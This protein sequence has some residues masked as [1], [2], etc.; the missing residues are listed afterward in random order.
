MNDETSNLVL[1]HRRAMREWQTGAD[2]YF[3]DIIVRLSAIEHHI[4]GLS[5]T[6]AQHGGEIDRI[7]ARL[8]RIEKRL[9]LSEG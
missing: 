3:K 1:E 2:Q 4:A 9:E 7:K 5:M 8:D 6:D